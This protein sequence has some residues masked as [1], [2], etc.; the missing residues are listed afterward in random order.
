[1]LI[2]LFE[3]KGTHPLNCQKLVSKHLNTN[4][5]VP[6]ANSHIGEPIEGIAPNIKTTSAVGTFIT[7][8]GALG[9]IF[10]NHFFVSY[11]TPFFYNAIMVHPELFCYHENG[12][13]KLNA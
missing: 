7:V 5:G 1:V 4:H 13:K 2:F 11:H 3:V 6:A 12:S 8:L 10:K 9:S